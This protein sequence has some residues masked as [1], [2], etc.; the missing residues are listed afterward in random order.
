MRVLCNQCGKL[1]NLMESKSFAVEEGD[2]LKSF[3]FCSDEHM[4]KFAERK[5]MK[6]SKD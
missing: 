4:M 5:N 2:Q 3:H 1:L 6:I